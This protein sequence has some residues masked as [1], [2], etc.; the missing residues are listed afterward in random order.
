ML[1]SAEEPTL[2]APKNFQHKAYGVS[3]VLE[4]KTEDKLH[5]ELL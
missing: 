2:R 1:K 5:F 4:R 3:K